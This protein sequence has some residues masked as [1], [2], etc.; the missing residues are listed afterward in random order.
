MQN[1]ERSLYESF[2]KQVLEH[3]GNYNFSE[4]GLSFDVVIREEPVTEIEIDFHASNEEY[5]DIIELS[6]VDNNH[7]AELLDNILKEAILIKERRRNDLKEETR[8]QR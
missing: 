2:Q 4:V 1:G 8:Q 7:C 5:Y 6:I 3:L